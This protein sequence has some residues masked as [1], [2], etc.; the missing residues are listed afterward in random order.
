MEERRE[1]GTQWHSGCMGT[2]PSNVVL[3]APN[4]ARDDD[5]SELFVRLSSAVLLR[6]ATA[7]MLNEKKSAEGDRGVRLPILFVTLNGIIKVHWF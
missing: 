4:A 1:K 7:V 6:S 3:A 2:L 5:D